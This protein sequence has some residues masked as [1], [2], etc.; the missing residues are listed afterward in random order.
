MP[1][2]IG[3]SVAHVWSVMRVAALY[4]PAHDA[5]AHDC[6]DGRTCGELQHL[7]RTAAPVTHGNT[8]DARLSPSC[9]GQLLVPTSSFN[10]NGVQQGSHISSTTQRSAAASADCSSNTLAEVAAGELETTSSNGLLTH[11]SAELSTLPHAMARKPRLVLDA[12]SVMP[13]FTCDA[14]PL[15][16]QRAHRS[17]CGRLAMAAATFPAHRKHHLAA[18]SNIGPAAADGGRST[19]HQHS[20]CSSP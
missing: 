17:S 16:H 3:S 2:V 18:C 19:L 9:R 12:E 11:S 1:V 20:A 4:P 13:D 14:I 15:S 10:F 6:S 5:T 8:C 7:W